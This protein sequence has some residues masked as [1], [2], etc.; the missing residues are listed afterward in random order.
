MVT[1]TTVRR[2]YPGVAVDL[3]EIEA[4]LRAGGNSVGRTR[5]AVIGAVRRR[6]KAFTAEE[7]A[8]SLPDVHVA[9]VYRTLGLL[10]E[11]GA[12]R[13]VHLSHGPAIYERTI[14]DVEGNDV[15]HLVCEVCDRHLAVPA[16]LFGE[17]SAT[18]AAEHGF[19]L[20]GSHFAIVGRCTACATV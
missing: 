16:A 17:V 13:H 14:R 5:R 20:D 6:R 18:L 9:T 8:E 19:L 2:T 15:R 10:E 3:A 11:V 12:V 4:R 7:L 1:V